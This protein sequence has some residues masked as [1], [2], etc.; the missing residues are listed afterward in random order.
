MTTLKTLIDERAKCNQI[1]RKIKQDQV[2]PN[3]ICI[4]YHRKQDAASS[5]QEG[6]EDFLWTL[7]ITREFEFNH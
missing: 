7:L 1:V 4:L 3:S 2:R 6:Y 5:P